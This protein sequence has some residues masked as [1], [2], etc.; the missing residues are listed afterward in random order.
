MR[1]VSRLRSIHCVNSRSYEIIAIVSIA[2]AQELPAAPRE[3]ERKTALHKSQ[4]NSDKLM[5][6]FVSA[7]GKLALQPPQS[8]GA[9]SE[10]FL[11]KQRKTATTDGRRQRATGAHYDHT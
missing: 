1:L 6:N 8:A 4:I 2:S 11:A 10:A 5:R 3:V 7:D 9:A